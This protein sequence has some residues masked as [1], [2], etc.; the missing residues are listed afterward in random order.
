M[1]DIAW[2]FVRF[3]ATIAICL[4]IMS[5]F[6]YYGPCGIERAIE[7]RSIAEN[8]PIVLKCFFRTTFFL[9][10]LAFFFSS[11]FL[12]LGFFFGHIK[13]LFVFLSCFP[14]FVVGI[15]LIK[16]AISHWAIS[17]IFAGIVLGLCDAFFIELYRH[18]LI[19]VK[20]VK[21]EPYFLMARANGIEG[22]RLIWYIKNDILIHFFKILSSKLI[23]L[24]SSAVIIE[25]IF[26]LKGIGNMVIT[27]GENKDIELLISIEFF[28]VAFVLLCSFLNR[29]LDRS[30][31][32]RLKEA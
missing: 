28:I 20:T 9:I 16:I 2:D 6:V 22:K 10:L 31:D 7:I 8:I 15:C 18:I 19:E 29:V 14:V 26:N 5:A 11:L 1:R 23:L 24:V 13:M 4:L 27:A 17:F 32:Q 12:G 30:L 25:W 21:K 3:V